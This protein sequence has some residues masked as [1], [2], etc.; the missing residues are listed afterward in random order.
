MGQRNPQARRAELTSLPRRTLLRGGV[1]VLAWGLGVVIWSRCGRAE[2]KLPQD[3]VSYQSSPKNGKRCADCVNYEGNNS[4]R[5][6]AGTISPDG[7][8]RL[9]NAR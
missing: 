1:S 5:V 4:C 3:Q 9:W 8:C 7:W 6:V 2:A